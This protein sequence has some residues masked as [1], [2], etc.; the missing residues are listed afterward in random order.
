M[1][2]PD[3]QSSVSSTSSATQYFNLDDSISSEFSSAVNQT[4]LMFMPLEQIK[5]IVEHL[6]SHQ[7]IDVSVYSILLISLYKFLSQSL[8]FTNYYFVL[9]YVEY[10]LIVVVVLFVRLD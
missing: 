4:G 3:H 1:I 8:Y 9:L 10:N 5:G 6:G 2:S 7:Q